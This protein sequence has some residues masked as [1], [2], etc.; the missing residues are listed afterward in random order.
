MYFTVEWAYGSESGLLQA[1][2]TYMNVKTGPYRV[3]C[4]IGETLGVYVGSY[5]HTV[6]RDL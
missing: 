1:R 2:V 3:L 5:G 6:L 4:G